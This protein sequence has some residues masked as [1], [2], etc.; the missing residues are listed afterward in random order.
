MDV[1]SYFVDGLLIDTGP[2]RASKLFRKYFYKDVY[3]DKVLLTH[4]HEDHTGNAP[5]LQKQGIDIYANPIS[6]E[7]LKEKPTLPLYR[8]LF[9]GIREGFQAYE[10]P[11]SFTVR[12][13]K[14]EVIHTPSHSKDH[15]CIYSPEEGV[16]FTGDVYIATRTKL[17][18]KQENIYQTI[19]DIKTMLNYDFDTICCS[20]GGFVEDGKKALKEKM[21]FLEETI[22]DI[23]ELHKKGSSIN[24]IDNVLYKNETRFISLISCYE[25]SSRNIVESVLYDN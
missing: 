9:W 15:I 16:I 1:C 11:E 8:R 19:R 7:M 2:V 20:H 21:D 22:E 18:Y 23:L 4:Y 14:Y 3:I 13:K 24:E 10:I 25:M 17:F 6:I 12:S 5:F